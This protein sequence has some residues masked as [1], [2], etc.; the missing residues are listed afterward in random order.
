MSST[1]HIDLGT[2][3][4]SQDL[5]VNSRSQETIVDIPRNCANVRGTTKSNPSEKRIENVTESS[6]NVIE[7]HSYSSVDTNEVKENGRTV[8]KSDN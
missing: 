4:A 7:S 3:A 2:L 1:V 5:R 6:D 8:P